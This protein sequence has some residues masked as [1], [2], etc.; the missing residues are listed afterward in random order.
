MSEMGT[1]MKPTLEAVLAREYSFNVIA[2][3]DGGYVI[4]FPD[5]PGCMTQIETMDEVSAMAEEIRT[6]WLETAFELDND[7]PEP[8]YPEEYSGRFVL[9]MPKSLHRTLAEAA[10]RDE[11][12]LNAYA[13]QLLAV[14]HAL[15]QVEH[16]MDD[17]EGHLKVIQDRLRYSV[18]GI[19]PAPPRPRGDF[20]LVDGDYESVAA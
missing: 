17:M 14:N 9:R 5:L 11:V 10:E 13:C 19:P 8:S 7:I 15:A 18:T 3:P 20:A 16:R 6:L 2:D 4:E 12:S 1:M